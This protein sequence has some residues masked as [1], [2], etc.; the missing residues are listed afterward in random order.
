MRERSRVELTRNTQ[1][2]LDGPLKHVRAAA[3][4]AALVPLASLVATPASADTACGSGGV[5]VSAS[6]SVF[7][8]VNHN[9]VQDAGEAGIEGVHVTLTDSSNNSVTT[10]TGPDGT[11]AFFVPPGTYTISAT[12]PVGYTT[13]PANQ[14]GDDTRDSDG[15]P[16]GFGD[17]AAVG[18]VI[19]SDDANTDFGFYVNTVVSNP[20]TGTLGYWKNHPEAWQVS[21]ITIGG[22][23]YSRD[24]AI[25]WM[26]RINKDRTTQMFAQLVAAKLNVGIGNDSSCIASTISY[27]DSW[28]STYPLGSNVSGSS[29]AWAAGEPYHN[30]LD[31]YNNGQ[32]CAPHRK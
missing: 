28:L 17:S 11:Y 22:Q 6:G 15:V 7:N 23:T 5:C 9:G 8:D 26:Q 19:L 20:G 24:Q 4:A 31:A 2:L 29:A 18:V 16:N 27:A 13:S 32:L 21:S 1:R 3:L 30:Q 14:G 25:Y 12:T 10:E